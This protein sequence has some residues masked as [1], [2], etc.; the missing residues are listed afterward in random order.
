MLDDGRLTVK[1]VVE[2]VLAR[3]PAIQRSTNAF[4]HVDADG[5]R[6]TAAALDQLAPQERGPLHGVPVTIKD[7]FVV[8]GM[9]TRAGTRAALPPLGGQSVLVTRLRAAGAV[10]IGKTNMHEVALGLTGDNPWTGP[11]R[12]PHDPERMA[13]GSSSGSAAAL[14]AGAGLA[15]LGTDTAGS[16]RLPASSCGVV[17]FKPTHGLLTLQGSVPLS[18][19]LDHAGPMAHNVADVQLLFNV[20]AGAS[21]L[22]SPESEHARPPTLGVPVRFLQ[23]RLSSGAAEVFDALVSAVRDTGARVA[24]V[25]ISGLE[26]APSIQ[27]PVGWPQA[28]LVHQAALEADPDSFSPQVR[29]AL[30]LGGRITAAEHLTALEDRARLAAAL[31]S[32]FQ[33][34]ALD[35]LLLPAAPFEAPKLDTSEVV[36]QYG[37]VPFRDAV[38]PLLAPFSLTGLPTVSMPMG[39]IHNL[40]INVQLVGP[41][42]AD[43]VTLRHADWL[44][45]RIITRGV[46]EPAIIEPRLTPTGNTAVG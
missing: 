7:L 19:N 2:E 46:F 30:E 4:A 43:D 44:Q 22:L 34:H 13:G 36:L 12:N 35:G 21:P 23:G 26:A 33:Q 14:A 15:S 38:L 17:A 25:D 32:S 16:L 20:L 3:V 39:R 10:V 40:P 41:R 18:A 27:T 45:Q 31:A 29:A 37:S 1:E 9:P 6:L 42:G 8:D 28:Y 5:A 24:D 11:V